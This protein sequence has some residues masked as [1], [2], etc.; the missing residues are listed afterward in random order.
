MLELRDYQIECLNKIYSKIKEGVKLQVAVLATGLGK[1]LENSQRVLTKNWRKSISEILVGE[2]VFGYDG[3]LTKVTGVF[4]QGKRD[5]YRITFSDETSVLCDKEHLWDVTTRHDKTKG[6]KRKLKTTNELFWDTQ[7]KDKNDKRFIPVAKPIQFEKKEL[8]IDPYVMGAL[9]GDGCFRWNLLFSSLDKEIVSRV[10]AGIK[11]HN[12]EFLKISNCDYKINTIKQGRHNN[13]LRNLL[14]EY[15][16]DGC[17]SY[18]K[19]IPEDYLHSDVNDRLELLRGLMD[20]DGSISEKGGHCEFSTASEWLA[21]DVL[22][23]V[24]SLWGVSSIKS[25]IPHY[26]YKGERK[27]GAR[28][29]RMRVSLEL[30]PF[31]V[32][33]KAEKHKKVVSQGRTKSIRKIEKVENNLCT[34]IKIEKEDWLFITE[35]Y[36]ITHNTV[37]FAQMPKEVKR[38]NKKVLV[39]A[40][41]EEL[42]SQARDKILS[43]SPELSVSIEQGSNV[44]EE[45]ADVIIASVPTLGRANSNR[46]K[47]FDPSHFGLIII[48]EVHHAIADSYQNILEYFGANK[49]RGVRPG[50]PV[51]IWFTATPNRKDN[52]GLDKLFDELVFKYDIRDGIEN[53]YLARIKAF[54]IN[55]GENL[56]SVSVRVWDFAIEELSDAVNTPERNK[57]V[58]DSYKRICD[59]EKALVFAVDVAHS[60]ALA[61][62]FS[63]SGYKSHS[64]TWSTDTDIRKQILKDFDSWDVQVVVNC[65]VLTEGYDNPNIRAVLFARPTTSA[66]LYIQ[67]AGRGT[68]LGPDKKEVKYLDFVDNLSKHS[69]I[70]ASNLIWLG[71][72]IK[73]KWEDLMNLQE[74][75]EE[76]LANHPQA[77]I[78]NIDPEDLDARIKEV[79]IFQM[80]QLSAI[81]KENSK[82]AW[83]QFLD[84][85]R[86]SLGTDEVGNLGCDIRED[87]LGQ[88]NIMFY[89]TIKE[90]PNYMNGFKKSSIRKLH[91]FSAKDQIEALQKADEYIATNYSTKV[92]LVNQSA[93]RRAEWAT[94]KQVAL[95]KKF[96]YPQADKLSKGEAANLLSKVFAEKKK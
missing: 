15:G 84:G 45:D 47:K 1:A 6:R 19:F 32:T 29:Y 73:V 12:C 7:L 62:A 89:N 70:S 5:V 25:R 20:T 3:N 40:H 82:Y 87:T 16:L 10:E 78:S 67:M 77:D 39:L 90:T 61:A 69:I 49:D 57:L 4:P 58:V 51:V 93:W 63:E 43:V 83:T 14:V 11:K 71:K 9:I 94:E 76:L 66:S 53:W 68:R 33:R 85:F 13:G 48:D 36:T 55:T 65:M 81:V 86:L 75:Y 17:L 92:N 72:P 34:C 56:D 38:S 2:K 54:T 21:K 37:I 26:D 41:R 22:E 24:R 46:I 18:T 91:S 80:A 74:K 50:H 30:N 28:S 64:V 42:L 23:L 27:E 96:G 59:G 95:L 35:G 60:E 79:D 88:Y 8:K 44:S 31:Y 52:Q